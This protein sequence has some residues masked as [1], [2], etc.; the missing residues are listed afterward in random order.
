MLK[1]K[2]MKM[3]LYVVAGAVFSGAIMGVL[4]KIPGVGGMLANLGDSVGGGS[5]DDY[6]APEED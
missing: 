3:L 4:G 5:A 6:V 1:G 2:T